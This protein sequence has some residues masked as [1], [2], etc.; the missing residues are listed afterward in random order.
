MIDLLSL[1]A[2][3]IA[4]ALNPFSIAAV[5]YLLTTDKPIARGSTFIV[6]TFLFYFT[7]G[8]A[9]MEGWSQILKNILP[10]LPEWISFSF[11]I[12]SG[13]VCLA[14]AQ[15]L[16]SNAKKGDG[17][18]YV[19]IGNVSLRAIFVFA[20]ASTLSDLPTAIP[21]FAALDIIAHSDNGGIEKIC[22]LLLYNLIFISPLVLL[23][24]IKLSAGETVPGY[25]MKIRHG[26]EWCFAKLLPPLI[27][28]F[29]LYL[30]ANGI[31]VYGEI[32]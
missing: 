19:S 6:G 7:A 18:P 16:Y 22:L 23:L 8:V 24:A 28:V 17:Q 21:Y 26:V 5:V 13:I 14:I 27:A 12:V 1:I 25:F 3:G 2:L 29:G 20:I 11:Y 9:L 10:G 30:L 31:M 32:R 15:H 4:D